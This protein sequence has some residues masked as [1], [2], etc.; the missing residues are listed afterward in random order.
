MS[1]QSNRQFIRYVF[2]K[3][4]K[5]FERNIR[6]QIDCKIPSTTKQIEKVQNIRN[7]IQKYKAVEYLEI[8]PC[9]L[10][11]RIS[12]NPCLFFFQKI[13]D[14]N[15]PPSRSVVFSVENNIFV[16]RFKILQKK[17]TVVFLKVLKI[18]RKTHS[19]YFSPKVNFSFKL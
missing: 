19:V 8:K 9:T 13:S 3:V 16:T 10:S 11:S 12:G 1:T 7:A 2:S 18:E 4:I 17:P 15:T 14:H 5:S 6:K